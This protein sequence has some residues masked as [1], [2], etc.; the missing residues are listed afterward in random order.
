M[1]YLLMFCISK[2][3]MRHST[4]TPV[5]ESVKKLSVWDTISVWFQGTAG[6]KLIEMCFIQTQ[7]ISWQNRDESIMADLQMKA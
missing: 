5:L 1:F 4:L 2:N 3:L 7:S 6:H